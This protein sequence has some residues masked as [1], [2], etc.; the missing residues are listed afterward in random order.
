[1]YKDTWKEAVRTGLGDFW[2][3]TLTL[4]TLDRSFGMN[5]VIAPK[6]CAIDGA[7]S[8]NRA[9]PGKVCG[10]GKTARTPT[11][12]KNAL[13]RSIRD[14]KLEAHPYELIYRAT[15]LDHSRD[16][17]EIVFS[18]MYSNSCSVGVIEHYALSVF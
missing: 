8:S 1:M 16:N 7:N 15:A 3:T 11:Q 14:R 5:T 18:N 6:D 17:L 12:S 4:P 2:Q 13:T 9:I 10:A